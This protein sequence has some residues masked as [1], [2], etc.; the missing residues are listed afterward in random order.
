MTREPYSPDRRQGPRVRFGGLAK[1]ISLPSQGLYVPGKVVNLSLGGCGIETVSP[2]PAGTRAEFVLHEN[3]ASIRALGEVRESRGR[4]VVGVEFLLVSAC[5]QY[6]LEDLIRQLV[7]EQA[8]AALRK[9]SLLHSDFEGIQKTRQALSDEKRDVTR[10]VM[11]LEEAITMSIEPRVA[12][13]EAIATFL[14][15]ELD[16][17]V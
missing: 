11:S 4:N 15:K 14:Y 12:G 8:I 5:G 17:F 2:L 16:L 7:R 9:G 3:A 13:T 1:I 10:H 6:L